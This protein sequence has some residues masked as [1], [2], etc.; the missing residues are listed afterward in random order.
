MLEESELN[1]KEKAEPERWFSREKHGSCEP[2]DFSLIPGTH[3][4]V[5][6]GT[7]PAE[8][9]SDLHMRAMAM[10][11]CTGISHTL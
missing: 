10:C 2:G 1:K 7:S 4:A 5:K 8:L 11:L 6:E 3:P 9:G